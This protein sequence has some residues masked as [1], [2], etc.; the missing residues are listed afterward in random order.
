MRWRWVCE[1]RRGDIE[2]KRGKEGPGSDCMCELQW[3]WKAQ[4]S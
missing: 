3:P 4:P 2:G 1:E